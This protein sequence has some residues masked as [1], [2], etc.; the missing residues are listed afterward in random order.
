MSP[1]RRLRRWLLAIGIAV[2]VLLGAGFAVLRWKFNGAELGSNVAS[3]LNK[4]MRGRI[5]IG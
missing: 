4:R 1:R 3:I 5:S 2:V